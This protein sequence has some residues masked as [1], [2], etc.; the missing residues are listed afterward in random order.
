MF[1]SIFR[2]TLILIKYIL[3]ELPTYTKLNTDINLQKLQQKNLALSTKTDNP[4]IDL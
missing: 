1:T 2:G 4:L 3:F